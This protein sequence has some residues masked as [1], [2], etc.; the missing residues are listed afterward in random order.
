MDAGT[1]TQLV[2]FG[3]AIA[4]L[5]GALKLA[6]PAIKD[7]HVPLLM[8]VLAFA[9]VA[10]GMRTGEIEG[11]LLGI[12]INVLG[13]SATSQGFYSGTNRL[14]GA[15]GDR[16]F[17]AAQSTVSAAVKGIIGAGQ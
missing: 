14:T 17:N 4:A 2:G 8:I 3:A 16:A 15:G 1:V 10:L 13:Q 6:F 5:V 12:V 11:G 9:L 7:Q